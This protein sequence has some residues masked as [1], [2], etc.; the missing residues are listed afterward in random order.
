MHDDTTRKRIEALKSAYQATGTREGAYLYA[1]KECGLTAEGLR[2]WARRKLEVLEEVFGQGV[3]FSD[4]RADI[5]RGGLNLD[6]AALVTPGAGRRISSVSTQVD[7]DGNVKG[8]SVREVVG[9]DDDLYEPPAGRVVKTTAQIGPGGIERVWERR[10]PDAAADLADRLGAV[11]AEIE[12]LAPSVVRPEVSEDDLHVLYPFADA[13]IG[14]LCWAPEAGDDWDLNIATRALK[15]SADEL[16]ARAPEAS[17]ATVAL[18]GD[19]MHFDGLDAVTPTS[20]H[21]LDADGRYS[22]LVD[23]AIDVAMHVT[24][25]AMEHHDNVTLLVAEGN[26]DLAGTVWL[27]KLFAR[28]FENE[29]R[30]TVIDS[31]KPYYVTTFGDVFLGYHHGHLKSA[32]SASDLIA[33][34]AQEFRKE[35]GGCSKQYI[36]TGHRHFL[37]VDSSKGAQIRQHPTIAAK[38]A[39]A[40]RHGHRSTRAVQAI[41][42]HRKFGEVVSVTVSADMLEAAA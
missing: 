41:A 22:K 20:G 10:V 38:D 30:L 25:R 26:H 42:Y 19:W 24:R 32:K 16:M 3:D 28:L 6:N 36:H 29:P 34:F 11:L 40:A 35:W 27:R 13:H 39:H 12:P 21:I 17:S 8:Q 7:A 15:A 37:S 18:L 33:Y 1:A 31:P 23:T 9:S 14:A 4:R 5:R 2:T